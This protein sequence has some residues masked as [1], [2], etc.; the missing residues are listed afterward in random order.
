MY[1]PRQFE[2]PEHAQRVMDEHPLA[3]LVAQGADGF[4]E[5]SRL[6]LLWRPDPDWEHG[7]LLGHCARANPLAQQLRQQGRALALFAGPHAY[8]SPQVYPDLQRVPTW[9]YVEV[10]A[11]V[12][13]RFLDPESDRDDLLKALIGRHEPAY[14]AQWRGLPESYTAAMLKGIEAFVLPVQ[15]LRCKLKLNQHR[16][17]SHAAMRQAYRQ[18]DPQAQALGDWMARLGLGE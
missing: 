17:E 12:A 18:G 8:M 6:P 10:Q 15:A 3:Y 4:A 16:P 2:H 11:Q 1:L 9:N 14:A 13:V 7:C 5:A